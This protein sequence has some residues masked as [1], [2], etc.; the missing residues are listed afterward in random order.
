VTPFAYLNQTNSSE[1]P[2]HGWKVTLLD[3]QIPVFSSCQVECLRKELDR[4]WREVDAIARER[5]EHLRWRKELADDLGEVETIRDAL[6]RTVNT[7]DA[8]LQVLRKVVQS[9][10]T[11]RAEAEEWECD[12][13]GLW[14]QH[15][16]W[17]AVDE[18]I[19][20]RMA[21]DNAGEKEAGE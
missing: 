3:G 16:W 6:A 2:P 7:Q 20:A 9:Y 1:N 19:E 18:A 10:E 14:A 13:L 21:L 17:E 8:E 11:L 15:G 4:A 5:D 12:G